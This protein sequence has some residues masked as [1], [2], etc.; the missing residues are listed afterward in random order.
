MLCVVCCV[1]CVV[2]GAWYAVCGVWFVVRESCVL[3]FVLCVVR[4]AWCVVLSGDLPFLS[5][6]IAVR[7]SSVVISGIFVISLVLLLCTSVL[8]S[9]SFSP[10]SCSD[11][12]RSLSSNIFCRIPQRHWQFLSET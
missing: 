1:L 10:I 6:L 7:N 12:S 2:C 3:C 9:F 8:L 4:G 11:S 5:L